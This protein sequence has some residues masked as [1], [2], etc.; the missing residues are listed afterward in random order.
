MLKLQLSR[1]NIDPAAQAAWRTGGTGVTMPNGQVSF[2]PDCIVMTR[3]LAVLGS[4]A[5]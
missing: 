3:W 5:A 4:A 2:R 1:I